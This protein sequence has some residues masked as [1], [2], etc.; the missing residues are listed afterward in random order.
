VGG[1]SI[2]ATDAREH[3][4][5]LLADAAVDT[6]G[7]ASVVVGIRDEPGWHFRL[8]HDRG[9]SP[10]ARQRLPAILS[11]FERAP[12]RSDGAALDALAEPLEAVLIPPPER[13]LGIVLIGRENGGAIRPRERR[14]LDALASIAAL[15]LERL[16]SPSDRRD[17]HVQLAGMRIDLADQ[18]VIL[19]DR[20]VRLTPSELRILLFLAGEPGRARTRREILR[21]VWHTEHVGDE[22][23]CDAHICNLRR[24]IER[25]PARP[26]RVVTIRNVGY[27]LRLPRIS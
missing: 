16:G 11:A 3:V 5:N 9:L 6:L 18:E 10:T 14:F 19:D 4:A 21:H 1:T 23:A 12:V 24:K 8:L 15:A 25:D 27:A 2:Y 13:P 26:S 17:A 22:R 7:A 20:H